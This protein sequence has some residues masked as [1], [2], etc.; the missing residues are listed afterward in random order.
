MA[1]CRLQGLATGGSWRGAWAHQLVQHGTQG[2]SLPGVQ[3]SGEAS[4]PR[5][6]P[7]EDTEPRSEG[8]PV[9]A[10]ASHF[11]LLRSLW[12]RSSTWTQGPEKQRPRGASAGAGQQAAGSR[13]RTAGARSSAS[14]A[15]AVRP[16]WVTRQPLPWPAAAP[17]CAGHVLCRGC[18]QGAGADTRSGSGPGWRCYCSCGRCRGNSSG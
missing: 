7:H 2:L 17:S 12:S 6:W 4:G 5:S 10:A 18:V 8:V 9:R 3:A 14:P 11:H 1:S 13:T 16:R 15:A